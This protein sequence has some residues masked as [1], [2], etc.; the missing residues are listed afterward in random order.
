MGHSRIFCWISWLVTFWVEMSKLTVHYSSPKESRF[1][2]NNKQQCGLVA[3]VRARI[4]CRWTWWK[5]EGRGTDILQCHLDSR[6]RKFGQLRIVT[7]VNGRMYCVM[8]Y[9]VH[10]ILPTCFHP[11]CPFHHQ[12]RHVDQ[13]DGRTGEVWRKTGLKFQEGPS[14][15]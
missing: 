12:A 2:S 6:D 4:I 7:W 13:R 15:Q 14:I 9:F 5:I 11:S 1:E 3:I 10:I 8:W